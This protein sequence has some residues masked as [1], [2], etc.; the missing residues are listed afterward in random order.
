MSKYLVINA[1]GNGDCQLNAIALNMAYNFQLGEDKQKWLDRFNNPIYKDI[2]IE[3]ANQCMNQ[4]E[5]ESGREIDFEPLTEDA[6]AN[7]IYDTFHN[8][9]QSFDLLKSHDKD[10]VQ[11][12]VSPLI[13]SQIVAAINDKDAKVLDINDNEVKLR[14]VLA[15]AFHDAIKENIIAYPS[16]RTASGFFQD[17]PKFKAKLKQL[18]KGVDLDGLVQEAAAHKGGED[19]FYKGK[20]QKQIKAF[21][22]WFFKGRKVGFNEFINHK[23]HGLTRVGNE[24]NSFTYAMVS[25]LYDVTVQ[26]KSDQASH[27]ENGFEFHDDVSPWRNENHR[28]YSPKPRL[29]T[30][31]ELEQNPKDKY[32]VDNFEPSEDDIIIRLEYIPGH[33]KAAI[34]FKGMLKERIEEKM[35]TTFGIN[36]IRQS[37]D[38]T[39]KKVS[40]NGG[41]WSLLGGFGLAGATMLFWPI[42]ATWALA[43][44]MSSIA[45]LV[46]IFA[47][48]FVVAQFAS[49]PSTD[50][51]KSKKPA[52]KPSKDD[53]GAPDL[54]KSKS[55]TKQFDLTKG[56]KAENTQEDELSVDSSLEH[57]QPSSESPKVNL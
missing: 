9:F 15:K 4:F 41:G 12:L 10:W 40:S 23:T 33:Y 5:A 48:D 44:A 19:E 13:R 49:S 32:V 3:L 7:D 8:F 54:T 50:A 34:P 24:N 27:K 21:K 25:I 20:L 18:F 45:F 29:A 38:S 6:Q 57:T 30:E 16:Q 39:L 36:G 47:T 53:D 17:H 42:C 22:S 35:N 1:K 31:E 14:G 55:Y 56:K 11:N 26:Y 46:G 28:F 52:P 43:G 37:I 2:Y 51:D